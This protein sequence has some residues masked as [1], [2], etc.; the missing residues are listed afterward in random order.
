MGMLEE[1]EEQTERHLQ[2]S[3]YAFVRA[4]ETLRGTC[5]QCRL[6]TVVC[7]IR[8]S[9]DLELVE[10]ASIEPTI[11]LGEAGSLRYYSTLPRKVA[12]PVQ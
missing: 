9:D 3:I 4:A 2:P 8:P 12:T 1:E 11:M 6:D 5:C 7:F 10:L